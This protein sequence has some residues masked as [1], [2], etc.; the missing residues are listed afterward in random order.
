VIECENPN[1][2]YYKFSGR[3]FPKKNQ[4][5]YSENSEQVFFPI[6]ENFEEISLP[7]NIENLLLRVK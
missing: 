5:N 3:F 7:L 6:K 4:E 2:D 1:P